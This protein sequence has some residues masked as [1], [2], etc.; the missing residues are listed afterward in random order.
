MNRTLL[1]AT[2]AAVMAAAFSAAALAQTTPKVTP[3]SAPQPAAA[4]PAALNPLPAP[5][6]AAF[7]ILLNGAEVGTEQ[8][9]A[10]VSGSGR[11]VRSQTVLRA[12]GEPEM[13]ATGDLHLS[14]DGAPLGYQWSSQ[15]E[16]KASGVVEFA[17]TTA[18][19]G[20][21]IGAPV[22]ITQAVSGGPGAQQVKANPTA[23]LAVGNNVQVDVGDSQEMVTVAAVTP[24][25]FSAIFSKNHSPNARVIRPFE[26][27]F[28]FP[29]PRIA[30]LDNNLYSQYAALA[31]LYDWNAKGQQTIPVLI[32]QDMTPGAIS[33]ESLG[34]KKVEGSTFETLRVNTADVEILAY[35]DSR[36]RLMRVEVPA[37]MVA[38][39]RR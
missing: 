5:D 31:Q 1:A 36:H 25:S 39:V 28:I 37:A 30:V 34:Q 18:K 15:G 14:A 4:R 9:E 35:Y 20:I 2:T 7:R 16:R 6:K 22:T 32:P 27:D 33:V 19:T 26:Q 13:R 11:I 10:T 21:L 38:I 3:A 23:D 8:F 12:P 24:L 17:D 29:S